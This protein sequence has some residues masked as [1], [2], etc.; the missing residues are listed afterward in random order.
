MWVRIRTGYYASE[1]WHRHLGDSDHCDLPP[2]R[3]HTGRTQCYWMF[4]WTGRRVCACDLC[5]GY[6]DWWDGPG[7]PGW[8]RRATR[9]KTAR[10]T[11]EYNAYHSID[12]WW[13]A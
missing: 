7:S 9:R 11:A 1:P 10:W 4:V 3:E 13:D 2:L 5:S 6:M 8:D 12:E